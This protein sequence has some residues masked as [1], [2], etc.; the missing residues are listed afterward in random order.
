VETIE[1]VEMLGKVIFD[2]CEELARAESIHP[3]WPTDPVHAQAIVSEESGE[4]TKA[5]LQEVYEPS[6]NLP[7]D[8]RTEAIHTAA[9]ALR[10]LVNFDKYR[11]E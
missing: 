2:V 7:G 4:L 5:V 8:V 10:F 3:E 6:K 1:G 11:W 9:M